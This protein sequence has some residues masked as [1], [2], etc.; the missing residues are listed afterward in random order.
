M[1]GIF[2]QQCDYAAVADGQCY[3]VVHT[4]TGTIKD[5]YRIKSS[6]A[7]SMSPITV[8]LKSAHVVRRTVAA[9]SRS[10]IMDCSTTQPSEQVSALRLGLVGEPTAAHFPPPLRERVRPDGHDRGDPALDPSQALLEGLCGDAWELKCAGQSDCSAVGQGRELRVAKELIA[11]RGRSGSGEMGARRRGSPAGIL[12]SASRW[13]GSGSSRQGAVWARLTAPSKN[14][15][16]VRAP[17][18]SPRAWRRLALFCV[19]WRKLDATT[20]EAPSMVVVYV[21]S[22]PPDPET[23]IE[24]LP[25]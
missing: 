19:R 11:G 4:P 24:K 8:S 10:P 6:T 12:F 25:T 1:T 7:S 15:H 20:H 3:W 9:K 23:R 22:F 18:Q 14:Q 5:F 2:V 16:Y 21:G 17:R 13:S